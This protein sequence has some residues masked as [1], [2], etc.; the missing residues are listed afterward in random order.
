MILVIDNYDSFT[1]NLVQAL[2]A[3]AAEK[4]EVVRNDRATVAELLAR[5]PRA[6]VVSPGPG[7]PDDA[8]V[9]IDLIRGARD[10]PLLGVCLGHQALAVAYGGGVR[11]APAPVHGKTSPIHHGGDGLFAGLPNPFAATRYHSLVVDR[12]GLPEDLEVTATTEDDLVMALAHRAR[13][14]VG[15]QFHP[16]SYMSREGGAIL[17]R[18][19]ELAG[20]PL[21]RPQGAPG[22]GVDRD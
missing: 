4:V 5:S 7:V 6:I 18:F 12:T 19:L 10:I 13:P 15:V 11:R 9:S 3:T 1:Y 17:T 8:G 22:G 21:R 20:I 2:A 14:H 16:E